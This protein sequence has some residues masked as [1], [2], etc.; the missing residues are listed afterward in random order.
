MI[1]FI[2][3]STLVLAFILVL[4]G[5][6]FNNYSSSKDNKDLINIVQQLEISDE[7][8][9]SVFQNSFNFINYDPSVQTIKKMQENFKKLKTF[10]IDIS[11][12]EEIFNAKL[13]QLNYFKSANSIA[14]NSKLYLFELAKNYFGELEQN[15]ET[16]KNNYRTMSSML[17]VLSTE[18]I[19]QK[20]TLNQLKINSTILMK[21]IKNDTKSENLQLFLKHY[22]M[23]VKQISIMQDNS[24]IYENNSLMKELKQLNTFTQNA[25]EQSNLFKF[26]IALA[27]FG[28]T[29]VLFVFFILLTLKKVIMPIHTLEKLSANLASKEAN[30]HSRLNIDP[31]SELGQSAQYINSFISTVQN[32][33]IEAIENAKSSHQNSQK[34]KNNS[35]ILENSSNSQHEQIQGVKEITYVLDDHINLAGNLAQESIE[36][37]QDIHILM[38]KVEL[39]LSELVNLINENNEK[40]QNVV[41][42]MDSLTQSA[43]NIIEITNSIKDIADQTNLL[44]LNAAIEAARAGEHGRGFAVVAD[45]VGQLADKTSKSLLNI[46][47]TVNT[48]VQQINDNKA[49]MDLIHDSMKETSSK[50]NDLQQELVNSMHKLESSIESTQTMKD[51]SMEVKDKMLILGTNIDKVNEL[52]NSVKDLSCEIN[53]ISQNV[54]NGASKLSEKL[55][56]FQ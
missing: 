12:A 41:A 23:I 39:T 1:K 45:E 7:K 2:I 27:V 46:N 56:S 36:N 4:L 24:S 35:M 26:Y 22:K 42:N 9:N 6:I 49:L 51:K 38:D 21:E 44:A 5:I 43:D 15:H 47:A 17:S 11:K 3:L 33:I 32:S 30:L 19:L 55:S 37:M 52:A 53:N 20:T 8:I 31:K 18:N 25:V 10:G 16:N 14:V 48:I 29:L 34:L 28:I 50:T 40:E 13:I 54:L